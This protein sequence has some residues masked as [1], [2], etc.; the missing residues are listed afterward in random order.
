MKPRIFLE[1]RQ[2]NFQQAALAYADIAK[3]DPSELFATVAIDVR[4]YQNQSI[5]QIL[6]RR[7][8]SDRSFRLEFWKSESGKLCR[9]AFDATVIHCEQSQ[10]LLTMISTAAFRRAR[11]HIAKRQQ[12]LMSRDAKCAEFIRIWQSQK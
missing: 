5:R 11:L 4:S 3:P 2:V 7:L 6:Q 10:Y 9:A 8:K 12:S 1:G